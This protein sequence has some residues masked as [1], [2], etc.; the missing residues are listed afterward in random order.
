V[1]AHNFHDAKDAFHQNWPTIELMARQ[2]LTSAAEGSEIR[3][4]LPP[5]PLEI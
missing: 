2:S 5:F 1:Q 4:N 3:L